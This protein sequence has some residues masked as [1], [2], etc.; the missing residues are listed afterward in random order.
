MNRKIEYGR[1]IIVG[2]VCSCSFHWFVSEKE[3]WVLDQVKWKAFFEDA[4]FT[5]PDGFA[6]RFGIGVV[7]EETADQF[8]CC[9]QGDLIST[10]ELRAIFKDA[11]P[12]DPDAVSHL[13]PA[14][15][16]DFDSKRLISNFSEPLEYERFAPDGWEASY[17]QF[18]NYI[19]FD[20]R[21]WEETC[22]VSRD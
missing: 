20:Q 15:F 10:S 16:I 17:G 8:L 12:S 6:D 21:Y 5:T 3:L 9:M 22:Q 2:V 4:G 14:L 11:D 1:D 13:F 19:P 18:D 7:N